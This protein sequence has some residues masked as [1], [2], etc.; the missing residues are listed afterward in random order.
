VA[1]RVV[2]F[3]EP[4]QPGEGL[5][6]GTVRYL[7]RGVPKEER[8]ERFFDVW[9][10]E[11]APSQELLRSFRAEA[12]WP[13]FERAYRKQ[14]GEP[15]ARHLIELIAALSRRTDIAIGCY[16]EDVSRCH[17]SILADVLAAAGAELARPL[18][19][20]SE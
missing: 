2:R 12:D 13:A 15:A 16:C 9:L 7:P 17:R 6:I 11:L 5:R 4:R 19:G 20:A 10:P 3:G 8:S 18:P 14:L 1:L